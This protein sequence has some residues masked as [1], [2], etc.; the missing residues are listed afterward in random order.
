[1]TG[2]GAGGAAGA[3]GRRQG[4]AAAPP[5]TS[6]RL[7]A[8]AAFAASGGYLA[9][10]LTITAPAGGYDLVGPRTFPL[11][12]GAGL[13][14]SALWM[15]CR[16]GRRSDPAPMDWRGA[17]T[18]ALVFLAYLACLGPLGYPLATTA[19]IAAAAR[20]LGSRA[21]RRDL[22]AGAILAAA[23]YLG[24]RLLLGIR[25]PAGPFG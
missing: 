25:L 22:A 8:A 21:W 20:A 14:A 18:A 11:V 4:P 9:A 24:F 3:G 6:E 23:A 1:M 15:G 12:I 17:A 16:P 7:F 5:M 10:G 2:R 13:A 19:F